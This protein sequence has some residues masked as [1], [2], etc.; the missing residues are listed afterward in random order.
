M[1]PIATL[2]RLLTAHKE[3]KPQDLLDRLIAE[4][5]ASQK[6]LWDKKAA[7]FEAGQAILEASPAE[8]IDIIKRILAQSFQTGDWQIK[9]LTDNL[10]SQLIKRKLPYQM[11]DVRFMLAE[12]ARVEHFYALPV[13]GVL[14]ALSKPLQDKTV[15]EDCRPLLL[16]IRSAS[17]SWYESAEK[18]KFLRL[19]QDILIEDKPK[20]TLY[21]DEWAAQAQTSLDR[22]EPQLKESW[23]AV[24]SHCA[25]A[26]GS[27]PAKKWLTK[28]EPL[29][30]SLGKDKFQNLANDWLGFFNK[31]SGKAPTR[32]PENWFIFQNK[33]ALL[34]ER[35]GDLLKGLAWLCSLDS[36]PSLTHTLAEAV[37]QGYR[38]LTGIGPRSAKV[39]SA[40]LYSLSQL[41]SMD[42]VAGLERA[43][44]SVKQ[45]SY[46]K[47]IARALD[48]AADKLGLSRADLE[49]LSLSDLAFSEGKKVITFDTIRAELRIESSTLSLNWFDGDEARK[50][51][52]TSVKRDF[53][54][55]LKALK[56][57]QKDIAKLLSAQ[58]DRLERLPLMQRAWSYKT[59]R[60]R[61]LDHSLLGTMA[62]KL[63][64][65]FE[66]AGRIADGFYWQGQI[67]DAEAKQLDWL[68]PETIVRPWHPVY[69]DASEVLAWREFLES[70]E[71]VQPFKQAHREVYLLTTAEEVTDIYSNRFA[72]HIVKQHQFNALCG[73]RGW[74]NQLRLM[75]DDS[76]N[77]ATLELPQWNLRAEFWVEGLGTVYGEDTNQTGTYLYLSTDQ[78]R[79]YSLDASPNYAHA[80]GGGYA[81]GIDWRMRQNEPLRLQDIPH[82]VFSEVMRDVDLFI[83]VA[84][85]ANDPTWF[86]GGPEGRHLDYWQNWSFGELTTSAKSRRELLEKIIPRLKI[87]SRCELTGRFL[88]V[89]GDLKTYKIHL[90]SGNILMEPNDQ[91][92]CIVPGRV[93][94]E[95]GRD[96]VFLPFEGDRVLSIILSKA[97]MLS[98]DA[99]IRDASITRQLK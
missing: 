3:E 28:A 70:R 62:G 98:E 74:K 53:A 25:G 60:E 93:S 85:V 26:S 86:D 96:K 99:K 27:K 78:I 16:E 59:W 11:E 22:L 7:D 63:I 1:R 54:E 49:E 56:K 39:A 79:F 51:V 21:E 15:L 67:V 95:I 42:A 55:E 50:A 31:T 9:R 44:L 13:Q 18:R 20:L 58:K 48:A 23:L 75:V 45:A 64:W 6:Y 33:G 73:A 65:Q 97:F 87:A 2:K 94:G 40:C 84:S 37:V 38:K 46:Q 24:L 36:D 41:E 32:N 68:G 17:E 57:E 10:L 90:G 69:Y 92:L 29:I 34:D 76:Y 71:I 61:Y 35:N 5:L 80:G 14:R 88:K 4:A 77:P 89:R 43:R 66:D 83:G 8:Q 82:V 91:Y 19:L 30:D 52:P 72:A 47:S 12:L 81:A